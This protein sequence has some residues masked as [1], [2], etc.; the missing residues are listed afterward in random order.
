[1]DAYSEDLRR[2]RVEAVDRCRMK[3][4]EAA[5]PFGVSLSLVKRYVRWVRGGV[6]SHR[7]GPVQETQT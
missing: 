2:K 5:H 1:M 4:S 7:G 6:R 3:N